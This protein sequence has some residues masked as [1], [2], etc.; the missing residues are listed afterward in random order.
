MKDDERGPSLETLFLLGSV[1]E[2]I[3]KERGLTMKQVLDLILLERLIDLQELELAAHRLGSRRL[4]P[5]PKTHPYKC[6]H[7]SDRFQTSDFRNAHAKAHP[8]SK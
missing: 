2:Q 1:M 8:E 3:L 7:C 4:P 6:P 5:T